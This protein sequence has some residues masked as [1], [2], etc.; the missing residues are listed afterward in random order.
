MFRPSTAAAIVCTV[1]GASASTA[2]E[3][4]E[5]LTI[6]ASIKEDA[7]VVGETYAVRLDVL[8]PDEWSTSEGGIPKPLLQIDVPGSVAL[9]G[10]VLD[11]QRALSRNEFL[12]QPYERQISPGPNMISFTLTGEPKPED[13]IGLNVIAYVNAEGKPPRFYRR[14]VEVPVKAG[15]SAESGERS[16]VSN[17]GPVAAWSTDERTAGH[18]VQIGEQAP[19][20]TLPRADGS[21]VTLSDYRGDKNVIVTTYRAFW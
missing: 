10:R 1:A 8:V 6:K 21:T 15:A 20:F 12:E 19:D 4:I 9:E 18:G 16:N 5:T 3:A 13:A 11:T 7:L 2:Q 14:R 17:W